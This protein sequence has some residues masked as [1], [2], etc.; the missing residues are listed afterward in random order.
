MSPTCSLLKRRLNFNELYDDMTAKK[1]L[2]V[3]NY[4]KSSSPKKHC[5]SNYVDR[6]FM[7]CSVAQS[8][9]LTYNI[10]SHVMYHTP[11]NCVRLKLFIYTL[12][13]LL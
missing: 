9:E 4:L 12:N 11:I 5:L 2:Y 1:E 7:T 10:N 8:I 3:T 6:I 13:L